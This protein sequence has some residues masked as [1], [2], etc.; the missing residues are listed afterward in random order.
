[1][2][3]AKETCSFMRNYKEET[4]MKTFFGFTTGLLAGVL[5]GVFGTAVVL[6]T[7]DDVREY[8]DVKAEELKG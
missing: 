5:A 3:F 8:L 7:D 1:M 2:I 6:L 4:T